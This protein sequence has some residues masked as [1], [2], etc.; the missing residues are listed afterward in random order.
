MDLR[1]ILLL[2]LPDSL[3]SLFFFFFVG[4]RQLVQSSR[5]SAWLG[6]GHSVPVGCGVLL[7]ALGPR[8][9]HHRA[10]CTAQPEGCCCCLGSVCSDAAPQITEGMENPLNSR[11]TR[12][13]T[14]P[15]H[16]QHCGRVLSSAKSQITVPSLYFL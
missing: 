3:D 6:C 11:S 4:K 16:T 12:G 14:P 5:G 9:G 13:N 1:A 2:L 8:H 10:P 7:A 15:M